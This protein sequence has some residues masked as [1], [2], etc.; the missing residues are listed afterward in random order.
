MRRFVTLH[1]QSRSRD[2]CQAST[3]RVGVAS[4][5]VRVGLPTSISSSRNSLWDAARGDI[6]DDS[7]C[8]PSWQSALSMVDILKVSCGE[9]E[10]QVKAEGYLEFQ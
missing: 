2:E 3:V 7:R 4:T 10:I 6:L 8:P 1:L 5:V 9:D